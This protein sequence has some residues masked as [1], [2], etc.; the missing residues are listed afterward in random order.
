MAVVPEKSISR[1]IILRKGGGFMQ[2]CHGYAKTRL[3][4]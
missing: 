3:G 4:Y 1:K 2:V